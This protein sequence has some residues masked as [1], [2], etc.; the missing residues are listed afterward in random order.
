MATL[1]DMMRISLLATL[2]A[3]IG[4]ISGATG[5]SNAEPDLIVNRKADRITVFFALPLAELADR[6]GAPPPAL[7][8]PGAEMA[9][10]QSESAAFWTW[11]AA[12]VAARIGDAPVAAHPLAATV[13]TAEG[14][15]PFTT[16]RDAT[17][18]TSI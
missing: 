18:A 10:L 6:I 5:R 16:P 14:I 15:P 3:C 1:R 2:L 13:H 12:G 7:I 8:Q 9:N 17:T 4:S 11:L